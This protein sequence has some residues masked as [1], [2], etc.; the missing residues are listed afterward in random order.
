YEPGGIDTKVYC[1]YNT[2]LESERSFLRFLESAR[3]SLRELG[4]QRVVARDAQVSDAVEQRVTLIETQG[5]A[6]AVQRLPRL[7]HRA[8]G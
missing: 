5:R 1:Y 4:R 3:Q 8:T 2:A 7:A 6:L